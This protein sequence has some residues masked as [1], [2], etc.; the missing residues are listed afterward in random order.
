MSRNELTYRRDLTFSLWHREWTDLYL[1]E[2]GRNALDLIDIDHVVYAEY[3]GKRAGDRNF[4][5]WQPLALFETAKDLDQKITS[6]VA[7]VTKNLALAA[8]IP[9]AVVLY[10][11]TGAPGQIA[12]FRV[13]TIAPNEGPEHLLAPATFA[14]W[15][16]AIHQ[17]HGCGTTSARMFPPMELAA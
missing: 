6:K 3:C 14:R 16:L 5:C 10:R 11:P 12:R 9:A 17:H 7:V 4:A 15:L 13:R 8:R 2:R 1:G